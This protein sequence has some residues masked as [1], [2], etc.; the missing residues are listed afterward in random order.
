[1]AFIEGDDDDDVL[2][3]GG[4]ADTIVGEGGND[5]LYGNGGDDGLFGGTGNDSL[6]GGADNDLLFATGGSNLLDGGSGFDIAAILF[7]E[8]G[9]GAAA[10]AVITDT[11]V[12][13]LGGGLNNALLG[14]ELITISGTGLGDTLD[15]SN[16]SIN[17]VLD[18]GDGSDTLIGGNGDDGLVGGPGD[19]VMTGGLGVDFFS[20]VSLSHIS[21]VGDGITDLEPFDRID[22]S[23][24]PAFDFIALEF[25]GEGPFTSV[26]GEMRFERSGGMTRILIDSDGDKVEDHVVMIAN[27]EFELRETTPGSLVLQIEQPCLELTDNADVFTGGALD[28]VVCGL[29]GIDTIEGGGGDDV[30]YGQGG[31]DTLRGGAND[32]RLYGGAGE[33]KLHGDGGMDR[34]FG[35]LEKDVL[36]GGTGNDY[37]YGHDG[38]DELKGEADDDQLFGEDGNDSLDGGAG[39][40]T[41]YGG[42]GN[43]I[44]SGIHPTQ[45][46][47]TGESNLLFGHAAAG[48]DGAVDS[49]VYTA[50]R[51]FYNLQFNLAADDL[52]A[53]FVPSMIVTLDSSNNP[54]TDTIFQV[55]KLVFPELTLDVAE[56]WDEL[57]IAQ[58]MLLSLDK[59]FS[60][61]ETV[62]AALNM[63]FGSLPEM[64]EELGLEGAIQY[65]ED[66]VSGDFRGV[67]KSALKAANILNF[68]NGLAIEGVSVSS[69]KT[70]V[71]QGVASIFDGLVDTVAFSLQLL[72]A[73]DIEETAE[74]IAAGADIKALAREVISQLY[75]PDLELSLLFTKSFEEVARELQEQYDY[76]GAPVDNFD[77]DLFSVEGLIAPTISADVTIP[78]LTPASG[79]DG[80]DV[81]NLLGQLKF[82][83]GVAAEPVVAGF[84][85]AAGAGNDR[86]YGSS[87]GDTI[88]EG[89]GD[90]L[91]AGLFDNDT[92]FG[93]AGDDVLFGNTGGDSLYGG[94]GDDFLDSGPGGDAGFDRLYGGPGDDI[95]EAHA[96]GLLDGGEG[97][98]W[99]DFDMDSP[100]T[101]LVDPD[102]DALA[103]FPEFGFLPIPDDIDAVAFF[104]DELGLGFPGFPQFVTLRD[105]E[106]YVGTLAGD[107]M[108]GGDA[109]DF[110]FGSDGDDS[111][112]GGGGDDTLIGGAGDD[113]IDGGVGI[114]TVDYSDEVADLNIDFQ[115]G[116]ALGTGIGLDEVFL[117]ENVLGGAGNDVIRGD[118]QNND[119]RGNDGDDVLRGFGGE[120]RLYGGAG[121]D[122]MFGDGGNDLL[123]G[124]GAGRDI[125]RGLDG[126]DVLRDT[127]GDNILDG[128]AGDDSITG[129]DGNDLLLGRDGEDVLTG[130]AGNDN[131]KGMNGD[132]VIIGGGGRDFLNGAQGADLFVFNDVSDST[133]D[134]ANRDT[135][136]GFARGGGDLMDLSAIDAD[137]N[138]DGDD[139]FTIVDKFSGTA[140]ELR[141]ELTNTEI[142]WKIQADIDGDGKADFELL[143]R[144][145]TMADDA[146]I[147]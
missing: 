18:G 7:A 9:L 123:D 2:A 86:V 92:I 1:M 87:G 68:T 135:I 97:E 13:E 46:D 125:L 142:T 36:A 74:I 118:G 101:L 47:L 106:F 11:G 136:L 71:V 146:F 145:N 45:S 39:D 128:G 83:P 99:A 117:V 44:L 34:L 56:L 51:T 120:D 49:V 5:R 115:S 124:G 121:E 119:F 16:A 105:N 33:D 21:S 58:M 140:G 130:N 89:S 37:L 78:P 79:T 122:R 139:A 67:V 69:I 23:L 107:T 24:I 12:E 137:I 108:I 4:G 81:L 73:A 138:T 132:D 54:V 32:D 38:N 6:F 15:A 129:G 10:N 104:Y 70:T 103:A 40:D 91:V 114:D 41:L 141:Y 8:Y 84:L 3:G 109:G 96:F 111:L 90:G 65:V 14:I 75:E 102:A 144:A 43:D 17:T 100:V 127:A 143:V 22:F 42:P 30:L 31:N 35:G 60:D 112:M 28:D 133:P 80:D 113:R 95:L 57:T 98:D 116:E 25:I 147:L 77:I 110:L 20:F 72:V 52:A 55:E 26:A 62:F 64:L 53:N 48:D 76:P 134:P 27:G 131:L 61:A 29:N 85:V 88:F 93:E 82:D 94:E 126:D 63:T 19:D 50:S 59:A 66:N